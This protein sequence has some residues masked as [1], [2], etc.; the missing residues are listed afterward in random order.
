MTS[1]SRPL[2]TSRPGGYAHRLPET[3]AHLPHHDLDGHRP[4]LLPRSLNKPLWLAQ[5]GVEHVSNP[6]VR[7]GTVVRPVGIKLL[8]ELGDVHARPI[9]EVLRHLSRCWIVGATLPQLRSASASDL[10]RLNLMPFPPDGRPSTDPLAPK[11]S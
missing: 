8:E 10:L 7:G 11:F 3:T 1:S 6:A 2:R 4:T 9:R 5:H